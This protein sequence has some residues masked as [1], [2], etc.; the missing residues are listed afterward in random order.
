M[1]LVTTYFC[2]IPVSGNMKVATTRDHENIARVQNPYMYEPNISANPPT[3]MGAQKLINPPIV[4]MQARIAA[5]FS[6]VA[7]SISIGMVT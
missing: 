5:V 2:E 6:S 1:N 3:T 4:K 7:P